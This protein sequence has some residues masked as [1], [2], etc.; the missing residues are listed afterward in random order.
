MFLC[1][2]FG[3]SVT[4]FSCEHQVAAEF[5]NESHVQSF[6]RPPGGRTFLRSVTSPEN[7]K[8][9][10]CCVCVKEMVATGV[11]QFKKIV[12]QFFLNCIHYFLANIVTPF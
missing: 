3:L 8:L 11:Q 1:R 12:E 10:I 4:D 5:K 6:S 7:D 9:I 2:F